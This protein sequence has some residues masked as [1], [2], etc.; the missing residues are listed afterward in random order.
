M[1]A[2]EVEDGAYADHDAVGEMGE[3]VLHELFLFGAPRA[4]HMI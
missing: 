1:A 2:V 3:E 4:T